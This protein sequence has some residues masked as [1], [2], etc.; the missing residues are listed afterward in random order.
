MAE[1][2]NQK[3]CLENVDLKVSRSSVRNNIVSPEPSDDSDGNAGN[4]DNARRK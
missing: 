1:K 3:I 4:A 2:S